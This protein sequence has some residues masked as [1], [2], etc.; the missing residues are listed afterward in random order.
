MDFIKRGTIQLLDLDNEQLLIMK[1]AHR[2][3]PGEK[4]GRIVIKPLDSPECRGTCCDA[5]CHG[6]PKQRKDLAIR[7]RTS[8]SKKASASRRSGRT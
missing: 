7:G 6:G 3:K 2:L 8:R 1:L 4:L 5:T